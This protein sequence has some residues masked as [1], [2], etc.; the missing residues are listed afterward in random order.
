MVGVKRW[1]V[2]PVFL[3]NIR[4]LYLLLPSLAAACHLPV[5][6]NAP[7]TQCEAPKPTRLSAHQMGL[8]KKTQHQTGVRM[9]HRWAKRPA[10]QKRTGHGRRPFLTPNQRRP[11]LFTRTACYFIFGWS[12]CGTSMCAYIQPPFLTAFGY[13]LLLA[14]RLVSSCH[15]PNDQKGKTAQAHDAT[16]SA[17]GVL[18]STVSA[19]A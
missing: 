4:R 1:I 17:N 3:A 5:A 16:G 7:R 6:A 19:C 11:L 10:K 9:R 15:F 14:L 18:H 13:H 8:Q 2:H 12:A